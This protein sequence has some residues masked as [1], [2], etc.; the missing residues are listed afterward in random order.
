[1]FKHTTIVRFLC[2]AVFSTTLHGKDTDS[3]NHPS[4]KIQSLPNV[5]LVS[6]TPDAEKTIA[7][8][9]RVSNPDNQENDKYKGL[10]AYCI[11]NKHWSPFEQAFM[12]MEIETS[13]AIATQ[14]LR[15][16]SFTFQQFSQRYGSANEITDQIVPPHLRKQ[17]HKN[18]Q[19]S[20]DN[21]TEEEQTMWEE[22]MDKVL[23]PVFDLYKEMLDADIAKECAR[24]I[25]PQATPTRMYV[26]GSIRSW[27][28]YIELRS[29]NGTQK[30]HMEVAEKCK[31][32]FIQELPTIAKAL[33]WTE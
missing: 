28:H 11:R 14:I 32:I 13:L 31:E 18:R 27:I 19:N 7:Y 30:E 12:T 29:A 21:L 22:K 1:M 2:L 16:R 6:I 9:T 5:N 17:D 10:I 25:L 20:I 23:A 4:R 24:F 26:S 15:H 33:G 3:E 8:I